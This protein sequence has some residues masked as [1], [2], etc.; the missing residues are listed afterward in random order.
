MRER[1]L[2]LGRSGMSRLRL[3][4][5]ITCSECGKEATVVVPDESHYECNFSCGCWP[6]G[7]GSLSVVLR[8]RKLY[9]AIRDDLWLRDE[10][11]E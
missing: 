8:D 11:G 1:A 5:K 4:I 10:Y 6:K 2:R 7:G 9:P 3:E